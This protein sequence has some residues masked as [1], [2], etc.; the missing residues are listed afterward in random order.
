MVMEVRMRGE[1]RVPAGIHTTIT[2]VPG[3]SVLFFIVILSFL[4]TP[5][6]IALHDGRDLPKEYPSRVPLFS[7]YSAG[8]DG[9]LR[10][11]DR[12]ARKGDQRGISVY[13]VE[14]SDL[15]PDEA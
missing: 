2:E 6:F 9:A 5:F 10:K 11:G 1:V 7:T 8:A 13:V 14:I 3:S 12:S 15:L 4:N